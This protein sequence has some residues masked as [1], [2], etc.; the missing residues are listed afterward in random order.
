MEQ[1]DTA[2]DEGEMI[3]PALARLA[4][5]IRR[6]REQAGLSRSDLAGLIGYTRQY[7]SLAEHPRRGVPSA[8][9]VGALDSTLGAGG[10]LVEMRALAIAAQ[11][12]RRKAGHSVPLATRG[13]TESVVVPTALARDGAAESVAFGRRHGGYG[14]HE[15]VLEQFEAQVLRL[16]REFLEDSPT[17][18]VQRSH[19]V[20][21]ELFRLLNQPRWPQQAR[22]LYAMASRVCGYLAIASSDFFGHYAAAEDHAGTAWQLAELADHAELRSWIRSLQSAVA[23]WAC[24][25]GSAAELATHALDLAVTRSGVSRA[26]AMQARALAR[27]GDIAALREVADTALPDNDHPDET[28]IVLF[29][30]MNRERCLGGAYL[31]IGDHD[32]A[33]THLERALVDYERERSF[34]YAVITVIR[35]DLAAVHLGHHDLQAAIAV[36]EPVLAMPHTRRLAGAVRRL[37]DLRTALTAEPFSADT[38]ARHWAQQLDAFTTHTVIAG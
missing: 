19:D 15:A 21:D 12:A 5:E 16:A 14:L 2:A 38:T 17:V 32:I 36:T 9:L 3:E 35:L 4:S 11:R 8:E 28:G 22:R 24:E 25:W 10:S 6:L 18:V 27:L 30:D 34:D 37:H 31:W 26:V 29:T 7:V 1:D 20:R 13:V 33:Q 23:F